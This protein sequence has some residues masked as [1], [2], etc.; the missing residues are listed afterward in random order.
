MKPPTTEASPEKVY[1]DALTVALE[2]MAQALRSSGAQVL[3]E[4]FQSADSYPKIVVALE[5]LCK[6]ALE[7]EELRRAAQ[8]SKESSHLRRGLSDEAIGQLALR[9]EGTSPQP[10]P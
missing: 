7:W 6:C 9:L 1:P 3:D 2:Q 10:Q 4:L 8:P 5:K